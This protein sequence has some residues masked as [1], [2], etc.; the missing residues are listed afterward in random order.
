MSQSTDFT[1]L[2]STPRFA[3]R[4]ISLRSDEIRMPDGSVSERDIVEHPG[5]VAIVALDAQDQV[6]MVRQWRQPV[7][8]LMDELPAG[9]LDV[10]HEPAMTAAARE[11]FEETA[12]RADEWHVLIDLYTSPGM[13]DEAIRVF[14]ARG[15]SDAHEKYTPEGEE[16]TMTVHRRPLADA[17]A[18]VLRGE[19]T[20]AA[21]V[22]GIMATAVSKAAGWTGLRAADVA[23]PARPGH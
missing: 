16:V 11:L 5:A 17:V 22:A 1:V 7:G 14:L 6:V 9:L 18:A 15:L 19:L 20:N 21:A 13:T 12:L 10:A 2:S 8:Q 4:V 23:W 3:G